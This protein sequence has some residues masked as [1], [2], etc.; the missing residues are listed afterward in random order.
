LPEG[1]SRIPV[2]PCQN[3]TEQ[4]EPASL[5]VKDFWAY[6]APATPPIGFRAKKMLSRSIINAPNPTKCFTL[7]Q[8][9]LGLS[10]D[11]FPLAEPFNPIWSKV[12]VRNPCPAKGTKAHRTPARTRSW[13]TT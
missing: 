11:N 13:K 1:E 3:K 12:F 2:V 5:R 4:K 7:A 8:F 9:G 6:L 10:P